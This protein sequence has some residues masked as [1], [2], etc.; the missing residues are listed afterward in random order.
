M[1]AYS[2]PEKM[3]EPR[4]LPVK[5]QAQHLLEKRLLSEAKEQKQGTASSSPSNTNHTACSSSQDGKQ[6]HIRRPTWMLNFSSG[7][8]SQ[9]VA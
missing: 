6:G 2:D 4:I 7:E 8:V 5:H 3:L 1:G 9:K